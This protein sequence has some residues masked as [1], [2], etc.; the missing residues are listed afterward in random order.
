[1]EVCMRNS[2]YSKAKVLTLIPII[3]FVVTVICMVLATVLEGPTHR[4]AIYSIF[5]FVWIISMFLS[6]LPCLV[7]SIL[8]TVFAA[9]AAKD[10][11]AKTSV[12]LI[13]G[14]IEIL[15]YVVGAIL[16]VL[17]FIGGQSV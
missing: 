12:F 14:I 5:A 17:M 11:S 9:K 7:L 16:A 6:P 3:V 4:G 8:G 1:M 10:G 15:I 13:L 2:S